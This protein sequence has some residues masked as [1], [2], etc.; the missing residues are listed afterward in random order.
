MQNLEQENYLGQEKISKLLLKF[1]IPCILSLLVSSIYNI[2]DQ[3][4]IG[5]SE[6]GYLGNAATGIVFPIIIV[7]HAIAWCFGDGNA[8]YLSICQ[9]RKDTESAHRSVGGCIT[10]TFMFGV[11]LTG[12]VIIFKQPI[13]YLF[14]ASDATYGLAN[15]YLNI[16]LSVLPLYM[17]TNM[18]LST[19]RADGS[20][21]YCMMV[22]IIGAVINIIL[23]PIFIFGLHLGI[24]GAAYA[25]IIGQLVSFTV[26]VCYF[27]KTKTFKLDKNSFI[28]NLHVMKEVVGL[29]ASTFITQMAI[30]VLALVCNMMLAKY[31]ALSKYGPD[32]PISV[33]SIQT[34][35]FTIVINIIVGIT[36]GAQPIFGYNY[37]A[38]RFDRVKK[39]YQL[40]LKYSLIVGSVSTAIFIFCPKLIV[41]MFGGG[42]ALYTE[43]AVLTLRV[44]FSLITC[45]CFIKMTSIFFQAVGHPVKAAVASLTRDLVLFVPLAVILPKFYGV[46]GVLYAAPVADF[47]AM[48][49]TVYLTIKFMKTLNN[50][51]DS[52]DVVENCVTES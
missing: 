15:D 46:K 38:K 43:F 28:P 42:S 7:S 36:L 39:T 45:T 37:G 30:V 52:F 22:T 24:K 11:I 51:E 14:G 44:S 19:I 41:A 48:L 20:P 29:G 12:I 47:I 10:L 9:G 34:K 3:I 26:C 32:I 21:R 25:T 17:L 8:A 5:N 1:S 33:I 49:L 31:G 2:V 4:F 35:V 18:M 50:T 16:L 27:R 40:V 13:L 6:L 23:D